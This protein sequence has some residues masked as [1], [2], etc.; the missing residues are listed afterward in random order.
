M[1]RIWNGS[2]SAFSTAVPEQQTGAGASPRLAPSFVDSPCIRKTTLLLLNPRKNLFY[3]HGLRQGGDLIRFVETVAPSLFWRSVAYL[4]EN[5]HRQHARYTALLS[6][7]CT[8]IRKAFRVSRRSADS[9]RCQAIDGNLASAMP[10]ADIA[11]SPAGPRLL[12]G[13]GARSG[14]IGP[15]GPDSF[16]TGGDFPCRQQ[17]SH[18]QPDGRSVGNAPASPFASFESGCSLGIVATVPQCGLVEGL[19]DLAVLWQ[20]DSAIPPVHRHPPDGCATGPIARKPRPLCLHRIRS[21][22]NKPA[23]MPPM[24]SS[25]ASTRLVSTYA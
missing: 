12:P 18:R 10:A 5:R 9:A 8:A 22:S 17:R 13:T 1:V 7:Y 19:F 14:L 6:T 15:Q 4:Q 16:V 3:C 2:N 20:A 23:K 25:T 24:L 11:P 21:R